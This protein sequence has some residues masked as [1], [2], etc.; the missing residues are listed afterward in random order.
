MKK[1]LFTHLGRIGDMILATPVL[2]LLKEKYPESEIS[3]VA[4]SSNY[5]IVRDNPLVKEI[6]IFDKNPL[7][8]IWFYLKIKVRKYDLYID[9]K[10]HPSFESRLVASSVRARQKI[11]FLDSSGSPFDTPIKKDKDNFG[12]H[13]LEIMMQSL[14]P[15][16]I[17]YTT[18]PRP[19]LYEN[20]K[21][22]EY[23]NE[24]I[25]GKDLGKR[26][27]VTLNISG[28]K[29][30]K[31]WQND[32]WIEFLKKIDLSGY[33][34]VLLYSPN[35]RARAEYL[36]KREP[37]LYDFHSRSISD[38][39]SLIKRSD[40]VITVDTA[41]VHIAAAFNKPIFALFSGIDKFWHKFKPLSEI[42]GV[43]RADA[44]DESLKSITVDRA[45]DAWI[46]FVAKLH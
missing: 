5:E 12:K 1:I 39:I 25:A 30:H 40:F 46:E 34:L 33:E 8:L 21:S 23:V 13:H 15:L 14:E 4:G 22:K 24:F 19:S 32:K 16:G 38:V 37:A 41:V 20:E 29:E 45:Y 44:E 43:A 26:R 10:D 35:D 6:M 36:L 17:T 7:N 11:G 27:L 9:P 2:T 28:S 42:Y 18:L 31:K 3:V